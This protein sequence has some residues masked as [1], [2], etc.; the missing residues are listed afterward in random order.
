MSTK[1]LTKRQMEVLN[2]M[3]HYFMENDQLPTC[4]AIA[5]RFGWASPNAAKTMQT[6]LE[7]RGWIEKN[8]AGKYR[9]VRS[10]RVA[11]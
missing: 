4:Q 8:A 5:D 7:V 1:P 9:F 11:S 10:G 6:A 3:K 2:F